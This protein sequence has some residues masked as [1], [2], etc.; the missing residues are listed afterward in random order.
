MF[1][2]KSKRP[3]G[4]IYVSIVQGY[5]DENNIVKHKTIKSYG[6]L[7]D[8]KQK[9]ENF[10][11]YINNELNKL[12]RSK[13]KVFTI[14]INRQTNYKGREE[15]KNLGYIIVKKVY[16]KLGIPNYL[17][18]KQKSLNLNYDLNQT[19]LFLIIKYFFYPFDN[20]LDSQNYFAEKFNIKFDEIKNTLNILKQ[21][22]KDIQ[23][24]M[25]KWS[26]NFMERNTSTC[27]LYIIKDKNGQNIYFLED[28]NKIPIYYEA[29]VIVNEFQYEKT[30]KAIYNIGE[31]VIKKR[32]VEEKKIDIIKYINS[33]I[34]K[35]IE[36]SLDKKYKKEEIIKVLKMTKIIKLEKDIYFQKEPVEIIKKLYKLFEIKYVRYQELRE[37]KKD[38]K[39]NI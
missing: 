30:I 31:I 11:V 37:L 15:E 38:L 36:N 10:D 25:W 26:K 5:R 20:V 35:I 23:E 24:I 39:I 12:N 2:K 16:Y 6:Y 3:N 33:I 9:H 29:G 18:E 7:D 14:K 4:K 19:A 22:K 17:K 32:K 28:K 13:N 34:I 27:T 1:I 21:Y 8:L